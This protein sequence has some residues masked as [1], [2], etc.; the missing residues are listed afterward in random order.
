MS[1][2]SYILMVFEGAATEP[3]ILENLKQYFL[4]ESEKK[5]V[6][7]VYGTVI[8]SLYEE[9]F[10]CG[11]FDEDLD[12][13]TIIK[14]KLESNG[15]DELKDISRVQVPE[16]YLFF[17]YDGHA[18]NADNEK[19][20]NILELFNNETENGKL[21]VSYP[22]VEAIKH[23][24]EGIDFKDI[25]AESNSSYKELVSQ[26]CDNCLMDLRN[27]TKNNWDRIIQEHSKK[28]NFIVSDEFLFPNSII[29]QSVIFNHQ[30]E[31]F[32]KPQN[33][34]AVLASFPLFLLDYYGIKR[35]IKDEKV[36]EE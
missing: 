27:L 25:I 17:D 30:K 29:E 19:L 36:I 28:A 10:I 13:F 11:E 1:K 15:S 12:L 16:I 6:K 31:K 4:N 22:M 9:F 3:Q 20:Q 2:D 26:N 14:E 8:Y 24:K 33:K 5:I 34:V 21:Y 7:A 23:L 35:F 18:T 32:I